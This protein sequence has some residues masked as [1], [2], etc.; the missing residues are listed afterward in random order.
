VQQCGDMIRKH[1][2]SQS[3]IFIGG[4]FPS[5]P[6]AFGYFHNFVQVVCKRLREVKE[7]KINGV[8]QPIPTFELEVLIPDDLAEDMKD[9]VA[10]ARDIKK[11]K[12]ISV[13]AA[14]PGL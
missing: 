10:V 7:A 1:I 11:W 6:L 8:K 12:Q 13:D 2:E 3:G 9:K 14:D 5:V 4:I